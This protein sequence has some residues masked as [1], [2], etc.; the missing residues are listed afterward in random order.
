ML[1]KPTFDIFHPFVPGQTFRPYSRTCNDT[2]PTTP[3]RW[4]T[5][6]VCGTY[7]I[8]VF[9]AHLAD[10]TIVQVRQTVYSLPGVPTITDTSPPYDTTKPITPPQVIGQGPICK[11]VTVYE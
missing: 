1:T 6:T 3:K 8:S 4:V 10:N 5:K 11:T 9:Y 7:T 2:P